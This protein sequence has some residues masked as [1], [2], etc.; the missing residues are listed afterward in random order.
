V[1]QLLRATG[2]QLVAVETEVVDLG[3]NN[4]PVIRALGRKL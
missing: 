3:W 2:L 1:N 4:L